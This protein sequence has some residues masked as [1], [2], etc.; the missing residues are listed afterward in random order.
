MIIHRRISP[1]FVIP[2]F[3]EIWYYD[4]DTKM[5]TYLVEQYQ[6]PVTLD[7]PAVNP[8]I[9]EVDYRDL[10]K[11]LMELQGYLEVSADKVRGVS[12]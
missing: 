7:I 2:C 1:I 8:G 3:K 12:C 10:E 11:V 5:N 4:D 9:E 6:L